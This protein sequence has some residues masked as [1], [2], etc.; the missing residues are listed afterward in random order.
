MQPAGS[1]AR[2]VQG[3]AAGRTVPGAQ[4]VCEFGRSE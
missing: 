4:R 3:A 2:K 1:K